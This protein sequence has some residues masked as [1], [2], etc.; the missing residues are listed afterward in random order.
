MDRWAEGILITLT[1]IAPKI[2]QNQKDYD[3]M[4]SYMLCATMALNDFISLGIT[5]DWATHS[6][7]HELTALEGVTHG[8]SLAIVMPALM[9]VMKKQKH[10]KLLQYGNRV[11]GINTNNGDKAIEETICAT[12]KF[13]DSLGLATT[14]KQKNIKKETLDEIVL[15]FKERGAKLG[16][17][18]I[19]HNVIAEI[20]SVAAEQ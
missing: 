1:E 19:D 10:A 9:Q 8:E 3:L 7:G 11:F 12:K 14:T 5:S 13:F 15:R 20:L 17:H 18:G 2:K 4:S 16:E 6:I